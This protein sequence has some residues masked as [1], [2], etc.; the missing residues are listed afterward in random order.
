MRK[1]WKELRSKFDQKANREVDITDIEGAVQEATIAIDVTIDAEDQDPA[2][3]IATTADIITEEGTV[4]RN[5]ITEEKGIEAKV[6]PDEDTKDT[7]AALKEEGT[8]DTERKRK[9]I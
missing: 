6:I 1:R 8:E 4:I 5:P 7:P 3:L 2:A 9:E